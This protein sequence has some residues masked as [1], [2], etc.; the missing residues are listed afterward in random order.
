MTEII[1]AG[2][3]FIAAIA[4][5]TALFDEAVHRILC[6]IV[7]AII[8][9]IIVVIGSATQV[10][11][12]HTGIPVK[13]GQV[14]DYTMDSGLNWHSPFINVVEMDNREQRYHFEFLAFSSDLQEV[15]VKGS[16]NYS[17]DSSKAMTLYKTV[18]VNY[19]NILIVPRSQ[20]A[21]K[22]TFGGYT[23]E[24]LIEHRSDLSPNIMDILKADLSK[25]GIQIISVSIEDIDFTDAFTNAVERKQVASQERL[26]AQIEQ[27]RL[28]MEEEKKAERDI[29]KANT[30][31]E[32]AKIGAE[33]DL[34][35]TKIQADA[36][37][38]AGQKE[39]A[40]NRAIAE[41]LT[42]DLL[43]YYWVQQWDGKLPTVSTESVMPI[44]DV[45]T[46]N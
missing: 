44:L 20:E 17:I 15:Q 40:K 7:G 46:N 16:V 18:G 41:W 26:T 38:Y 3:I 37:E 35:V 21:V 5:A 25:S 39:A 8:A 45:D 28:T 10:A 13:F 23:A 33:A 29:I 24:G 19:E 42:S 12:G 9:A 30:E 32:K 43:Y 34:E 11:T 31:A 4:I 6:I 22:T 2:I 36:A 14:Q 1:I 27:E